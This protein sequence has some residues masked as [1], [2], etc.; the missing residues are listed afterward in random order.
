MILKSKTL[1]KIFSFNFA[2]AM[3]LFP[4]ILI[5]NE[6]LRSDKVLINHEKIHLR[7]QVELFILPFYLFYLTEYIYRRFQYK[8][9][10]AAYRNISFE[11][12]AYANEANLKYL[13]TRKFFQFFNYL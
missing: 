3:A 11:K 8:T 12:E 9:H 7:Q 10:E 4:F 6:F 2:R 1:V 13:D 5:N